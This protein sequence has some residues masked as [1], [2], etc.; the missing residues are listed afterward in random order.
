[1]RSQFVRYSWSGVFGSVDP[2]NFAIV[3]SHILKKTPRKRT[4]G[5]GKNGCGLL[6]KIWAFL[7]AFIGKR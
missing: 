7:L 3:P 1:M 5:L 2:T 6:L 4:G